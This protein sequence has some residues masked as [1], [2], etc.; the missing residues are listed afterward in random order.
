[1]SRFQNRPRHHRCHLGQKHVALRALLLPRKIQRR[2]AQLPV[3]RRHQSVCGLARLSEPA[4]RRALDEFI[5]RIA[6]DPDR[7]SELDDVLA[8][9]VTFKYTPALL[10]KEQVDELIQIPERKNSQ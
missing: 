7:I 3:H 4:A 2:K 6:V 9:A 10:Q 1:M 8:D 5:P